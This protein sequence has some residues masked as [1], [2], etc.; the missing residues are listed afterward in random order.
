LYKKYFAAFVFNKFKTVATGY[1]YTQFKWKMNQS[2]RS[3]AWNDGVVC[4]LLRHQRI[5]SC[6]PAG[7]TTFS[8]TTRLCSRWTTST[9]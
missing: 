1:T 9:E 2:Y 7:D 6:D 8:G 5:W 4:A 3:R